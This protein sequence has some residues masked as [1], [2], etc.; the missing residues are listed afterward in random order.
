M[1][2]RRC[3]RGFCAALSILH[4]LFPSLLV[5]S[6]LPFSLFFHVAL[7]F[8]PRSL[9]F[10]SVFPVLLFFPLSL[11]ATYFSLSLLY[12]SLSAI[13]QTFSFSPSTFLLI[14][15]ALVWFCYRVGDSTN[16]HCQLPRDRFRGAR[17]LVFFE[18]LKNFR[19][20]RARG[21]QL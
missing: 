1:R 9:L 19:T 7:S 8:P 2:P 16:R 4:P 17:I 10:V 18:N 6:H 14:S 5:L 21:K 11:S 15:V 13:T 20:K 12:P 3:C